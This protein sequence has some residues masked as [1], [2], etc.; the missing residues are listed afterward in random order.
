MCF[1]KTLQIGAKSEHISHLLRYRSLTPIIGV[2]KGSD[3]NVSKITKNDD[4]MISDSHIVILQFN[5]ITHWGG[6]FRT[7]SNFAA[8]GDPLIVKNI[9]MCHAENSYLYIY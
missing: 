2:T 4:E 6:V 9:V 7:P 3:E 8:F 5:P 1:T